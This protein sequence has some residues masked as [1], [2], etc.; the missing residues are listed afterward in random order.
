MGM[1][2]VVM[3]YIRRQYQ[4]H[5]HQALGFSHQPPR[6]GQ[7][8]NFWFLLYTAAV[9]SL[10]WW[11][12]NICLILI[13]AGWHWHLQGGRLPPNADALKRLSEIRRSN[14][15]RAL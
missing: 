12:W 6:H 11:P 8:S 14:R 10:C 9:F 2:A 3:L 7:V 4:L 5:L 1:P 15:Q 13:G